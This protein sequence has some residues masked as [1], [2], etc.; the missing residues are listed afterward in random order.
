MLAVTLASAE[1][2]DNSDPC[3]AGLAHSFST[4]VGLSLVASCITAALARCGLSRTEAP[5]FPRALMSVLM[6]ALASTG[7]AAGAGTFSATWVGAAA[8]SFV[9]GASA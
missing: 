5:R 7:F 6:S 9:F 8:A 2:Y 3:D 1:A 4:M